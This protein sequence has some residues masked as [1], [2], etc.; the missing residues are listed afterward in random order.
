[1]KKKKKR[2]KKIYSPFY[3]I[4]VTASIIQMDERCLFTVEQRGNSMVFTSQRQG[5]LHSLAKEVIKSRLE[6]T[7]KL[8]SR[9]WF[10]GSVSF[11][12]TPSVSISYLLRGIVINN[13]AKL[14]DCNYVHRA[15]LKRTHHPYFS[16]RK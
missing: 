10:I 9:Y 2:A 15:V 6:N 3:T 11:L 14:T 5:G 16:T 7:A 1:M 8:N 13:Q 4:W 12:F